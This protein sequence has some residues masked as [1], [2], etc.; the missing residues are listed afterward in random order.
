MAQFK[1][2]SKTI[3]LNYPTYFIA[4]IAA[5]HD[6]DLERAKDLIHKAAD[7]GADAAKFQNFKAPKI[8]SHYGFEHLEDQ[9]SHQAKWKKSVFEVYQEASIDPR[10]TPLLKKTCQDAGIDYF[11]SPYDFE[12]IDEVDTYVDI[13]KVGSGDITWHAIID[14]MALK[15]KPIILGC[16]AS[17]LDEVTAAMEVLLKRTKQIVIM[18]CNT[19]YTGSHDN[20]NYIN[21]NALRTFKEHYPDIVLGLSDHTHGHATVLGAVSLGARMIEKHFTDDNNREGPDHGFAMNPQTWKD[22]VER[23]RELEAALGD[24]IKRIEDNE[25]K[26]IV[27]QRRALRA[28]RALKKGMVLHKEDLEPLRP[29]PCDGIDPFQM[30]EVIGKE[31]IKDLKLGCHIRWKDLK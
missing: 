24:G 12:S 18:Q 30:D 11:T 22:M 8:V 25:K 21:L 29:C 13:Y 20:L 7:A 17:T 27:V 19:N 26:S 10:W 9:G 14:Y 3:G 15:G 1:I 28:T 23:T 4:D 2:G 6:G 5:N 31:L 16:G